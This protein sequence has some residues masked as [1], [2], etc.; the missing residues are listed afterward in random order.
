VK[1]K[2]KKKK[3]KDPAIINDAH[4]NAKDNDTVQPVQSPK[5]SN[6]RVNSSI[7]LKD[8]IKLET[9]DPEEVKIKNKR[10]KHD[11]NDDELLSPKKKKKK[12]SK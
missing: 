9:I 7:E 3:K 5:K 4:K 1:K 8:N 2:K 12:K 6:K 11:V 10:K